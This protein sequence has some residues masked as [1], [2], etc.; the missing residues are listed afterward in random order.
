MGSIEDVVDIGDRYHGPSARRRFFTRY[1]WHGQQRNITHSEVDAPTEAMVF[2]NE[3]DKKNEFPFSGTTD[4]LSDLD[5]DDES[6]DTSVVTDAAAIMHLDS[7]SGDFH[8]I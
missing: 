8:T 3:G 1:R 4:P 7:T 6:I 2:D 5:S